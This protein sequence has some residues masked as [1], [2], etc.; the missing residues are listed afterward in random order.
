MVYQI[1]INFAVMKEIDVDIFNLSDE[2]PAPLV[3]SLLVARPTVGDPCFGRS[4]IAMI[5]HDDSGSMGVILNRM[6]NL[7]L[8][9]VMDDVPHADEVPVFLGGPVNTELMFFLHDLGADV[10]PDAEPLCAGLWVGGDFDALRAYLSAGNPVEGHIRFF[11]GYSGWEAGQLA[12][13]LK[14][15]DWVVLDGIDARFALTT[16]YREMWNSAVERFG[17]RYRLWRNWPV[18]PADN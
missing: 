5:Q 14:R 6:T 11:V 2:Q 13:E 17:D 18:E 3:G 7:C 12:G 16:P 8:S 9:D 4:V 10:L 1:L 15:H